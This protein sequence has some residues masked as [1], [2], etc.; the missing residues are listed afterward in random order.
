MVFVRRRFLITF[1]ILRASARPFKDFGLQQPGL[2]GRGRVLNCLGL[3]T[4]IHTAPCLARRMFILS[5]L[6]VASTATTE[7]ITM[8]NLHAMG[9][10]TA[11]PARH[12]SKTSGQAR[13]ASRVAL[14]THA[15][16]AT[17]LIA[18]ASPLM[19]RPLASRLSKKLHPSVRHLVFQLGLI[20]PTSRHPSLFQRRHLS[21]HLLSTWGLVGNLR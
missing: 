9:V 14:S 6:P 11:I 18:M 7:F 4:A 13:T 8:D 12:L 21:M 1:L 5:L 16:V 3:A 20:V 10:L 2:Q 17:L 19:A 15:T